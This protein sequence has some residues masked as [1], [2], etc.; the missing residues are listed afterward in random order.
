ME[1]FRDDN[2]RLHYLRKL[3]QAVR[4]HACAIHAYVLMPN[5]V[6]LL[7]SPKTPQSL[8]ETMQSV[9]RSYVQYFNKRH[10]RT[11]TLWEGRYR[12]TLIDTDA[13]LLTCMRYIELNP[14]RAGLAADP[15]RYRWSSHHANAL[16][17]S[18]DL[19]TPHPLLL[20]LAP[21]ERECRSA[22]RRL[23][24]CPLPASVVDAIRESTNKLWVLGD[25]DF[26]LRI[27]DPLGPRRAAPLPRGGDRKSAASRGRVRSIES[28]PFD[29]QRTTVTGTLK[30]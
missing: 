4:E 1:I 15:S 7:V 16:G 26:R 12:A 2:D 21:S 13:Y 11:G 30:M 17:K 23:F 8:P 19:V 22:Y 28:D 6:H 29:L 27:Q 24:E 14:V 3:A 20:S 10:E 18:D 5:H 9:G 25:A